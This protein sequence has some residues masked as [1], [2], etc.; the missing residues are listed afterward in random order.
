[1]AEQIVLCP[2]E[3]LQNFGQRNQSWLSCM[4]GFKSASIYNDRI[5]HFLRWMQANQSQFETRDGVSLEMA[6]DAYF[7]LMRAQVNAE[8]KPAHCANTMRCWFSIF[9]KFWKITGRGNLRTRCVLIEEKLSQWAK[10]EDVKQSKVF[11]E[12]DIGKLS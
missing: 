7:L 4:E 8:G 10:T 5:I 12:E 11:S 3:E 1:M 2:V 9:L 6:L